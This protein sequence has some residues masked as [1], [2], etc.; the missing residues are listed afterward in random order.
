MQYLCPKI[1]VKGYRFRSVDASID[2]CRVRSGHRVSSRLDS[3]AVGG[4][5]QVSITGQGSHHAAIPRSVA[6]HRTMPARRCRTF[7][8]LRETRIRAK[9][10]NHGSWNNP[11]DRPIENQNKKKLGKQVSIQSKGPLVWIFEGF[12]VNFGA[13]KWHIGHYSSW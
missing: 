3:T 13:L 5:R 7:H 6:T 8:S 12:C 9:S 4:H 2:S 1:V 11:W 10:W